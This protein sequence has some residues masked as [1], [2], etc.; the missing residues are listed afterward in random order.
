VRPR[1]ASTERKRRAWVAGIASPVGAAGAASSLPPKAAL[2]SDRKARGCRRSHECKIETRIKSSRL[3]PL[4]PRLL[5]GDP[6]GCDI[7][8]VVEQDEVGVVA[9]CDAAAFVVD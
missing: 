4:L 1:R 2:S 7:E 3:P 5:A 6:G 8:V 9:G